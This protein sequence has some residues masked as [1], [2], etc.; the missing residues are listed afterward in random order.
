M[1]KK[2][3][4][5]SKKKYKIMKGG[6]L[7][8][9]FFKF[10]ASENNKDNIDVEKLKKIDEYKKERKKRDEQERLNRINY[11]EKYLSQKQDEKRIS[12]MRN[13]EIIDGNKKLEENSSMNVLKG[14]G[15]LLKKVNEEQNT[16][17]NNWFQGSTNALTDLLKQKGL[18]HEPP[19]EWKREEADGLFFHVKEGG[20]RVRRR[21][22][23]KKSRKRRTVRKRRTSR[24]RRTVRKRRTS[25]KRRR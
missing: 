2:K 20:G 17:F 8:G 19:T 15:E 7:A 13:H 14:G 16:N 25:R 18:Q 11:R 3:S 1:R 22:K 24:K 12:Y 5:K 10:L 23:S 21:R 9:N 4:K 6:S